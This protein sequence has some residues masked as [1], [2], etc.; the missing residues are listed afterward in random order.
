MFKFKKTCSILGAITM[1]LSLMI[2]TPAAVK[3]SAAAPTQTSPDKIV[4]EWMWS[5]TIYDAGAD[6]AETIMARCAENGVT[7]VYLLVKGTKGRLAYLNTA[8]TRNLSYKDR[9]VLQEAIDAAHAHG[10]RLHAWICNTEDE[11][12]R[13]AN[14]RSGMYH[15]TNGYTGNRINLYDPGYIEYMQNIAREIAAYDVDGLHFDY[16]R[17]NH[18]S[19]GWSDADF[20]ALEAMGADADRIREIIETTFGYNGRTANGNY[21]FDLYGTDKDAKLIGE[22]RRNNVKNYAEA[23]VSA[24]R[25]A[26]PDLII[27]AAVMPEGGTRV[28]YSDLHYGQNYSDLNGIFDYLCLMAY[29]ADYN[30]DS[31]WVNTVA[32]GALTKCDNI[33]VGLQAYAPSDTSR[34]TTEI[35]GIDTLRKNPS[36]RDKILGIALFRTSTFDYAKIERNEDEGTIT[37]TTSNSTTKEYSLVEIN[38]AGGI[39]FKDATLTS[40]FAEGA[41][42]ELDPEGRYIKITGENIVPDGKGVITIDYEGDLAEH[43]RPATVKIT[44]KNPVCVFNSFEAPKA[45]EPVAPPPS[46]QAPTTQPQEQDGDKGSIVLPV[47]LASVGAVAVGAVAFALIKRK[48]H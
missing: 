34:L 23:V 20:A 3:A 32:T 41:T 1:S 44:A 13:S 8:Q 15:Y 7:D 25:E 24:A 28:A 43:L 40:G 37:V 47:V 6:G 31:S 10:I 39:T 18:L 46:T 11:F 17:Y 5:S 19:N 33:V 48:R 30:R 2:G 16:L 14:P 26:N 29:S 9:D 36:Y 35:S 27:S 38:A 4:G 45:E 21:A 22:Y 12:Y 42:V